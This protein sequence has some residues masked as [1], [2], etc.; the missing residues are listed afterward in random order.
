MYCDLVVV[1]GD[2]LNDYGDCG[3]VVVFCLVEIDV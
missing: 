1:I 3:F 2:N